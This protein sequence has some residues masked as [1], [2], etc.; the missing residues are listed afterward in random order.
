MKHDSFNKGALLNIG[1][2]EVLKHYDFD[3]FVFHDVDM[4]VED[5]R[6]YY[7]CPSSPRHMSPALDKHN[8]H[9]YSPAVFGGVTAFNKQD[10][11]GKSIFIYRSFHDKFFLVFGKNITEV[12]YFLTSTSIPERGFLHVGF[13][14]AVSDVKARSMS[15]IGSVL[16]F[17]GHFE[18]FH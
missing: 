3:C 13:F 14:I 7:G 10:F 5:D 9:M 8:Y 17:F 18:H 16:Y 12:V 2:R 4:M 6:N 1:F 15:L 11:T